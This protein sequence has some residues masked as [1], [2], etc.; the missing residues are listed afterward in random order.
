M[1]AIRVVP[2]DHYLYLSFLLFSI[3]RGLAS[4][5]DD[6]LLLRR[7]VRTDAPPLLDQQNEA[8]SL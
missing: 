2:L 3:V 8:F 4:M 5:F 1:T 6:P 7:A